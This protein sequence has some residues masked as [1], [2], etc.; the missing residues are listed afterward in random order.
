[1]VPAKSLTLLR[2]FSWPIM[3]IIVLS[4]AGVGV[5]HWDQPCIMLIAHCT[6]PLFLLLLLL[7][8]LFG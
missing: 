6:H 4:Q 8:F 3:F 7:P 5:G 1:M 2:N